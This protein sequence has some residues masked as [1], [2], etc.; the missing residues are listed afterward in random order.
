MGVEYH[1]IPC[2]YHSYAVAQDGFTGVGAGSDGADYAEGTHF[3]QGKPSVSRPGC[4][5]NI[6]RTRR[7]VCQKMMFQN[8]IAHIA[9]TGFLHAHTGKD[10]RGFVGFL[11][12]IGNDLFPL[13]HGHA[14]D[15]FLR[16]FGSFDGLVHIIEHTVLR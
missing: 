1:R 5:C 15:C 10:F 16:L 8:L 13:V 9:H 6:F 11:T 4:C 12:D 3:N 14:A 7:F 2:G